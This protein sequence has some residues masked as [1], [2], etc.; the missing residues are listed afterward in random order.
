MKDSTVRFG[1]IGFGA[2]GS[3]HARAITEAS[4]AE[5]AAISARSPE[6]QAAARSAHPGVPVLADFQE[7]LRREDI[8]AV[9]IAVPTHL[10]REITVAALQA[11]KAVLLEK[12][13]A[14]TLDDCQSILRAAESTGRL[15]ALG[16]ELRLSNLWGRVQKMI[17][18]G[19]IGEPHYC[20]I[21]LW[22][23]PYRP[24]SGGWRY[25]LDR[26]GNWILEE[27]IHFFDLAR[28]YLGGLGE[29]V[30]VTARAKA[31][32]P[33][34]PG[35]ADNFSALLDFPGGGYAVI[36]QTLAAF[37]HHQVAKV[38]GSSGSLW[39]SWSGAMDRTFTPTFSL[40]HHDGTTVREIDCGGPAG[41]VFELVREIE[42]VAR[43]IRTG[44]PLHATAHD[45][46]WAVRMCLLAAESA[47]HG[48]KKSLT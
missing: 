19:A 4:G 23:K 18:E 38:T 42:C 47:L 45:G 31:R 24:G 1:L 25:D 9:S 3:H 5:L 20:L 44:S 28:W 33:D 27:P 34:Q 21:E 35:L 2:W 32:N 46:W 29:P 39:A 7:L 8:E 13:M 37:E 22:R 30:A 6:S 36:S 10:H 15:L 48:E 11:G 41:E 14:A 26:V 40:K 16:F 43:A 12:P 17:A